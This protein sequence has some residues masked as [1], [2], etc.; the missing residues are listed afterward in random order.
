M[1]G[2]RSNF[3]LGP[4]IVARSWEQGELNAAITRDRDYCEDN[5]F[6]PAK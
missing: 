2:S 1:I 3:S 4:G 5:T 6:N